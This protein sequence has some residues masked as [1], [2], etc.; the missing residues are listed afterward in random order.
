MNLQKIAEQRVQELIK[1]IKCYVSEGMKKE[2]A[3]NIAK[4][5]TTL[6]TK[7]WEMVIKSV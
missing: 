3:I 1:E 2:T 6:G 4:N 7:Y 5:S